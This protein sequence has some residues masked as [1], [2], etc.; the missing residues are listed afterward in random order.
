MT[1][2]RIEDTEGQALLAFLH[3]QREAV[4]AIVAGL[5]E[6]AWHRPVVPS[7]WTQPGWSSTWA[8]PSGTGSSGW[9]P[10]QMPSSPGMRAGPPMTR[11]Q[12]SPVTGPQRR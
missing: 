5:D 7:G 9:W 11:R 8:T 2:N 6:E 10:A 4:L 12:R 1:G 3:A